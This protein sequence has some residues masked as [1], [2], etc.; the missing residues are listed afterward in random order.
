MDNHRLQLRD[1]NEHL[2]IA[3]M[4]GRSE[5]TEETCVA[6]AADGRQL[7]RCR[8]LRA[9]GRGISLR[10]QTLACTGARHTLPQRRALAGEQLD[11]GRAVVDPD[12]VERDDEGAGARGAAAARGGR[13]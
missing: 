2:L 6:L 10:L 11:A 3:I 4:C 13:G 5:R 7:L 8:L 9:P 12:A 1:S